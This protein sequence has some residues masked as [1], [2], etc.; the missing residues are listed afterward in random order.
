MLEWAK[1]KWKI[2]TGV[3]VAFLGLLSLVLRGRRAQNVLRKA[4]EAHEKDNK[5]N[6]NANEKLSIGLTE[7]HDD[8]VLK[9]VDASDRHESAKEE[10][11][12]E[13]E[14]FIRKSNDRDKL[15]S[16]IAEHIGAEHVKHDE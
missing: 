2:I 16:E 1:R 11:K 10:I 4:N 15:A 5:I 9:L 3:F 14:E 8:T 12:K 13:K 6:S 7:I